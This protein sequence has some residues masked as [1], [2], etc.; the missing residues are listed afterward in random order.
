MTPTNERIIPPDSPAPPATRRNETYSHSPRA[1]P[2]RPAGSRAIIPPPLASRKP[3]AEQTPAPE[4]SPDVSVPTPAPLCSQRS[5][6]DWGP[7]DSLDH[8]TGKR[9]TPCPSRDE[10]LPQCRP[11]ES[12]CT[13]AGQIQ[14]ARPVPV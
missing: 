6:P 9:P 7:P 10:F 8:S 14:F 11:H 3:P 5:A 4:K 1:S 13:T 2:A 12:N